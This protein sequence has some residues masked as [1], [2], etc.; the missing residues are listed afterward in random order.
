MEEVPF[1][2]RRV[3][4]VE[5]DWDRSLWWWYPLTQVLRPALRAMSLVLSLLAL[6]LSTLGLKLGSWLFQVDT[7]TGP[8]DSSPKVFW[9][10][11]FGW[12][13]KLLN[14]QIMFNQPWSWR[15]IAYV[16]FELFWFVSLFAL[17]G[18]L[19]VRRSVVELGQRTVAAWGE[20]LQIVLPRWQSYLWAAGMHLVGIGLLLLPPLICGLLA[21][22]STIGATIGGAML[23]LYFPMILG[24]GRFVLSLTLCFPL[25][26]A[27]ISTEKR[28]DAF[29]GFSRS[30]AYFFQRPVM[31]F[32]FAAAYL[33][34]GLI[35]EKI[36]YWTVAS[37]WWLMR[38][39]FL[40]TAGDEIY[41]AAN[42]YVQTGNM[43]ATTLISAYWFSYFWS[44]VG[45][46]YLLLRHS[47]D[48][49]ELD[50]MDSKDGSN[51]IPQIPEPPALT[52]SDGSEGENK[53]QASEGSH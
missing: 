21:S 47:V 40:W 1:D 24:L 32:G 49:T 31:A 3:P 8:A 10:Q 38:S 22:T 16:T 18:G 7:S 15:G 43:L 36:I 42:S 52:T 26:I 45:G 44:A 27:A 51:D 41:P 35:G 20:S 12:I 14:V 28:G 29:E 53:P 50:V 39:A 23:L 33:L 37:G 13:D 6:L 2:D 30:N 5:I 46:L 11:I 48:R 9:S 17:F 4:R 25:S 19:L 34:I